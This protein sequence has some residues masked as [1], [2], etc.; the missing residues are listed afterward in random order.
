MHE[1]IE[2]GIGECWILELSMPELDGQLAGDD[3]TSALLAIFEQ[4][5]QQRLISHA[6]R[7][8]PEIFQDQQIDTAKDFNQWPMRP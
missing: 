3:H 7:D 6:K 2:D 5:E 1:A 8:E 4:F